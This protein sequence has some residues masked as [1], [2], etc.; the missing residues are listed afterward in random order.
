MNFVE[1]GRNGSHLP[2]LAQID[3]DSGDMCFITRAVTTP[4]KPQYSL[5]MS[6]V[7][8]YSNDLFDYLLFNHYLGDWNCSTV[9]DL[10]EISILI[11]LSGYMGRG[12]TSQNHPGLSNSLQRNWCWCSDAR[13]L[14]KSDQTRVAEGLRSLI[15]CVSK[16]T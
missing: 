13:V 11:A 14:A 6:E 8:E 16:T 1:E 4:N 5:N 12:D 9:P 7:L 10:A 15:V 2:S 3:V